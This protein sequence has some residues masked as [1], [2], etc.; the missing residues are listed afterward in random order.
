MMKIH[1]VG[2]S[3][4]GTTTLAEALRDQLKIKHLDTD[5]F[6]WEKTD[7]PFTTPRPVEDRI[8]LLRKEMA[9]VDS[10]VLSGSLCGWGDV[11]IPD[12]D[13]VIFIYIPKDIRMARIVAREHE[14]YGDHIVEGGSMYE[15]SQAF[16]EW[17]EKYDTADTNMRSLARHEEWLRDIPRQVLRIEGD[18]STEERVKRVIEAIG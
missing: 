4:S 9:T 18:V 17:A 14:R 2:A 1:I 10:W 16:L 11:F 12:F 13:L 15:S 6:F 8:A 5:N 3:G 7:P